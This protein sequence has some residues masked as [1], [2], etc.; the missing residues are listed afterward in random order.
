MT[1]VALYLS[2]TGADANTGVVGVDLVAGD[3]LV[4]V[5]ND[6][7]GDQTF[8]YSF[9]EDGALADP[10]ASNTVSAGELALVAVIT[11]ETGS[12]L[13]GGDFV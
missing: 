3:E 1:D 7:V 10:T 8:V 6:L 11:E 4:F 13:V 9:V 12:V 2:F 5:I